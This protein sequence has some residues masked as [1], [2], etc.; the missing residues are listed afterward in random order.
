MSTKIDGEA[1]RHVAALAHLE[2]PVAKVPA[3][4][5]ELAKV[6][7]WIDQIA[8]AE[9]AEEQDPPV[10]QGLRRAD[11]AHTPGG[12]TLIHAAASREGDEVRVAS[13]LGEAT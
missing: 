7:G 5:E 8:G 10:A 1:V 9:L 12:A 6:V 4:A 3:V 13:V 11:Q 2:I